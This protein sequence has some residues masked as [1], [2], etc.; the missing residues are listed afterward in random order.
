MEVILLKDVKG[1]GNEGDVVKVSDGYARNYL[2]P[3]GFALQATK[4]NLRM[5]KDKRETME[6]KAQ[7]ELAAAEKTAKQ[8]EN[9]VVT[10]R[11]KAG[12]G[13]RLFGSVTAKDIAGAIEKALGIAVDRRRIELEEPIKTLGS[14]SVLIRLHPEVSATVR[15]EVESQAEGEK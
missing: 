1:L 7:R 2:I 14:Y 15:V 4:A 8:L 5:L 9:S 12:E 13:G 11:S 10:V 6:S 3:K